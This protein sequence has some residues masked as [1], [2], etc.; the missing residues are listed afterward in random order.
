MA[1]ICVFRAGTFRARE[2]RRIPPHSPFT[3]RP[4]QP[5][6]RNSSRSSWP[7]QYAFRMA[8]TEPQRCGL[9]RTPWRCN[10]RCNASDNAAQSNRSTRS[11][12]T[13][14]ARAS[15]G[16]T[17]RT[18]SFRS[19]SFPRRCMTTSKRVAVSSNGDM[20]SCETGMAIVTVAG[21]GTQRASGTG[22]SSKVII[23]VDSRMALEGFP[24]FRPQRS[25]GMRGLARTSIAECH[26][27]DPWGN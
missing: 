11:S 9:T 22:C 7:Q 1:A 8:S 12:A 6:M 13:L 10:A 24:Q 19:A 20:R 23:P 15:G 18:N 3:C 27:L 21:G 14:R 26:G 25:G 16:R 2:R 4:Q 5:G 17:L